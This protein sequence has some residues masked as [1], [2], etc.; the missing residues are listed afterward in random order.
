MTKE[1]LVH[2]QYAGINRKYT[3]EINRILIIISFRAF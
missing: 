2:K 1:M 3:V